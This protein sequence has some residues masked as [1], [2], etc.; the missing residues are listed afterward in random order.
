MPHPN[1]VTPIIEDGERLNGESFVARYTNDQG[2]EMDVHSVRLDFTLYADGD[3]DPVDWNWNY[4]L[5]NV[6]G[7]GEGVV[8]SDGRDT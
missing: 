8:A 2:V 1:E 5:S 7:A 6:L 3:V 4:Y